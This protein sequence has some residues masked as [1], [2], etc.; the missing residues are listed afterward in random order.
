M[1]S[2]SYTSVGTHISVV[3]YATIGSYLTVGGTLTSTGAATLSSTL[4]V[5]GAT[6]LTGTLSVGGGATV[7]ADISCSS[8]LAKTANSGT[9]GTYSQPF[10]VGYS[11]TGWA[12][13]SDGNLKT[14]T[15]LPYGLNE[16]L[17][18]NPI[19]FK[20]KTQADLADDNPEKAHIYYG[21]NARQIHESNTM[22]ELCYTGC[23]A[24][25][26]TLMINYAEI[27]TVLINAVKEQQV[28]IVE[29]QKTVKAL[30][31]NVEYT[32]IGK[33]KIDLISYFT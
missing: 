26:N 13:T 7:G 31:S 14:S 3:D 29:L 27:T 25:G 1:V 30:S 2:G 15:P 12:T 17:Q 23:G 11:A 20:F 8:L 18:I 24:D 10:L 6:T 28:L 21:V 19:A 22:P 33:K 16:I 9:I 32:Q 5:G 4:S